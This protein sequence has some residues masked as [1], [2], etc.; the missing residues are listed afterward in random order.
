M[1]HIFL[2]KVGPMGA[3]VGPYSLEEERSMAWPS[4]LEQIKDLELPHSFMV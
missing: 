2:I 4:G 1:L 3:S